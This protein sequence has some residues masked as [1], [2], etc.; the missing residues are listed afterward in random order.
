MRKLLTIIA[1]A[2]GFAGAFLG[3]LAGGRVASRFSA[4]GASL[5]YGAEY[6]TWFWQHCGQIGFALITLAFLLQ[7]IA[8]L[9]PQETGNCSSQKRPKDYTND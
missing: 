7:L 6:S 8:N 3:F 1:L 5:G 9:I 2:C 4:D